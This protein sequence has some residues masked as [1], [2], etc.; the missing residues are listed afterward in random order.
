MPIVRI[1]VNRNLIRQARNLNTLN[2]TPCI[3][4]KHKNKT[5][6]FYSV[7]LHKCTAKHDRILSCGAT[8][9]LEAEL[10]NVLVY[11]NSVWHKLCEF[12]MFLPP[13]S[14]F[15]QVGIHPSIDGN[16]AREFAFNS[17]QLAANRIEEKHEPAIT[18]ATTSGQESFDRFEFNTPLQLV[19]SH[20]NLTSAF[21]GEIL[22][23]GVSNL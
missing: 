20:P 11:Y 5:V 6:R 13:D 12:L 14:Q 1:H 16:T 4:V 17:E 10:E 3:S 9:Y 15:N 22:I 19:Q 8:A 18:I 2:T 7:L 21:L 23:F